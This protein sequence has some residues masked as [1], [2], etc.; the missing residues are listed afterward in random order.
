MRIA[1]W[2]LEIFAGGLMTLH[3]M[4]ILGVLPKGDFLLPL[5]RQLRSKLGLPIR[6]RGLNH[7][8]AAM[9]NATSAKTDYYENRLESVYS[10]MLSD[11]ET[12]QALIGTAEQGFR[13]FGRGAVMVECGILE[14]VIEAGDP[15]KELDQI[16]DDQDLIVKYV[17]QSQ[18][19]DGPTS[20]TTA[21]ADAGRLTGFAGQ[22]ETYDPHTSFVFIMKVGEAL[23]SSVVT[24][25]EAAAAEH[26]EKLT[27]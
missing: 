9:L 23:G 8:A 22:V 18:F 3:V 27:E 15:Q 2:P 21:E 7:T 12:M 1:S 4:R 19:G 25:K 26:E 11:E 10:A 6:P 24:L 5:K 17:P 13:E 16:A 20:N 14:A